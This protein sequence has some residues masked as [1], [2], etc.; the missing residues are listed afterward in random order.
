MIENAQSAAAK[1]FQER[2]DQAATEK[3]LEKIE[4]DLAIKL[5][6]FRDMVET[7]KKHL[8]KDVGSKINLD[9]SRNQHN[10][11]GTAAIRFDNETSSQSMNSILRDGDKSKQDVAFWYIK[12][13]NDHSFDKSIGGA[14]QLSYSVGER[15]IRKDPAAIL[16]RVAVYLG[17]RIPEH[18]QA[19]DS[20]MAEIK[21]KHFS[22]P[23]RDAP[24]TVA[25]N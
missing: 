15:W 1:V 2:A 16:G 23:A 17:T 21:T 5:S 19:I 4:A 25:F 18:A 20:A 3:A 11:N 10:L 22:A 12:R 13:P 14:A 7:L 8:P 6:P 24:F 9:V